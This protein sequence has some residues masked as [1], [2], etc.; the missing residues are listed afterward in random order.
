MFMGT[1]R[2]RQIGQ[3]VAMVAM[4][5]AVWWVVDMAAPFVGPIVAANPERELV[6]HLLAP[7]ILLLIGFVCHYLSH[8]SPVPSFVLAIGL[9]LACRP[10][11]EPFIHNELNLKMAVTAAATLILFQG[12]LET[13]FRNFRKLFPKIF[14]LAFPGVLLT[15]F[16]LSNAILVGARWLGV[17]VTVP[18]A[19]LL[20][21]ILA[22]TDPAAIIPLLQGVKFR[23]QDTKDIAVS[24]SALNDVVG[25]LLTTVFLGIVMAGGAVD[26]I[27]TAYQVGIGYPEASDDRPALERAGH[28]VAVAYLAAGRVDEVRAAL[29]LADQRIVEHVLGLRV[30]RA[31]DRNHVADLHHRLDVVV[32]G[33]VQ[34]LLDLGRQAV[35]VRVVQLDVKGLQAAQNGGADAPGGHSAHV[36]PFE[37]VGAG[38]GVGNVPAATHHPAVRRDVVADQRQD[39][40]HHVFAHADAVGVGDLGDGHALACGESVGLDDDGE[41]L[42]RE[43]GLRRRGIVEARIGGGRNAG[44][45]AEILG[46]ALG[47]FEPRGSLR[48]SEHLYAFS[49]EIVGEPGDERRLGADHHEANLLLLAEAGDR[50]MVAQFEGDDLGD[51]GD[52]GITRRA[53][54]PA[55]KRTLLELPGERVLPPP[56][57]YQQHV[58]FRLKLRLV[59]A[60][61]AA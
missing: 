18:V 56:A 7:A 40:H 35:A 42:I 4:I 53:I 36:H 23:N 32:I 9:G 44:T 34:L 48:R 55:E 24:E 25:A 16:L 28:G 43:I 19:L 29:H 3:L 13:S 31:V 61:P 58:Q 51:P 37:V 59:R 54:E 10:L 20:G 47:A 27:Q 14:L 5:V 8:R 26:S 21:A 15:G 30:Q 1:P 52:A 50:R 12:G 57:A 60:M 46:E 33:Q 39:H 11:L 38:D 49:F 41:L 2:M 22:S 17:E 45:R 6:E